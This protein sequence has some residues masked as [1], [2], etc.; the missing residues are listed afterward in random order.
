MKKTLLTLFCAASTVIGIAQPS[1]SPQ[2]T[3]TQNSNLPIPSA[4]IRYMDAVNQNVVWA[5][6]YD[7]SA[8]GL[9]YNFFTRTINGGTSW[10]SGTI[11]QSSVTPAIGD[12][13]YYIMASIFGKSANE[14][15]AAAYTKDNGG[16]KGGIFQT[17]NGGTTWNN[18]TAAGM[19]TNNAAFCNFVFFF[20]NTT[21]V[22]VGD[23][24]P[25]TANEHEIWR[26]TD[27]GANWTLVP[28][29]NIPNPNGTEYTYTDVYEVVGTTH[30]WMGTNTGRMFYTKDAGATWSVSLVKAGGSV[31]DVAFLDQN[32][33]MALV[34]IGTTTIEL[35]YTSDGG[36][37][38]TLKTGGTDP[39]FG[40]NDICAIPGTSWFA[41][42]GAGTG[43]TLLSF[44]TD[45]GD[46]WNNWGS[47]NIQ[48]LEMEFVDPQTGW[49]GT[50]SDFTN[51]ALGGWYKYN[52]PS[53]LQAPNANFTLASNTVCVG[54]AV[55]VTNSSTGNPNPSF[56]WTSNPTTAA[57]SS[58]TAATPTITFSGAGIYTLTLVATNSSS[59]SIATTTVDVSL[60]TGISENG[61]SDFNFFVYPN[62]AK[63]VLTVSL[64]SASL[65]YNFTVT[66]I[67][68]SVVYNENA[69]VSNDSH[70]L[71]L[72][73]LGK[74]VY[75]LTVS[76]N[77][78]KTTKKFVVE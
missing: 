31:S 59:I 51:P 55:T 19:Y 18:V 10:N 14:A 15:W 69:T 26:T 39:N 52:G 62:P 25:G 3:I 34:R 78:S 54:A 45:N 57:F 48:Y 20:D 22:V 21:G 64:P 41:S 40:R 60:C 32:N 46:T 27:G 28:G 16:S 61:L 53:L 74:G 77:G 38:W 7:G 58:S 50:F 75:F 67:L 2:W 76:N 49:A 47:T 17:T 44:S 9:N 71:N 12:T 33:G 11:V 42:C 72:S 35:Y 24:N 66:N 65:P 68:G 5:V 36:A 8:P 23:P 29:A 6:A 13:S 43:N 73:E 63:D 70:K 30:A 56:A 4:G 1:P 37:T